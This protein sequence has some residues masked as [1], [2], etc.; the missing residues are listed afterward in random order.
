MERPS[1]APDGIDLTRPSAARVYD[2][3]LGGAHNFAVDRALAER[4]VRITPDVGH[5]MRANRAFLRRAV[6]CLASAGIR[7]F[8]DIGSGIPTV[9]NVHEVAQEACPDARV[10]YIDVDPV[11]VTHSRAMLRGSRGAAMRR[12]DLREPAAIL[13]AARETG[14]IDFAEPVG[15]LLLGVVHFLPDSDDPAG[16][17]AR[18]REAVVAGS[19]LALSHVTYEGQPRESLTAFSL[20]RHTSAELVLRSRAEI[21]AY[22]DGFDVV[23]PGV[24]HIPLWRPDHQGPAQQ[25]PERIGAFAG[26]GRRN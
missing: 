19:Y 18:L 9:G 6:R 5:T 4:V 8:L 7:Q 25:H 17:V 13:E 2:Y 1:W 26:V 20:S 3:F 12:G 11:A 24:V 21:A 22:F 10:V 14:L 16:I 23:E 15:L